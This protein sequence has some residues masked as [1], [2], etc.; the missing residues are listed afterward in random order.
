MLEINTIYEIQNIGKGVITTITPDNLLAIYYKAEEIYTE[1]I[2][3]TLVAGNRTKE[4]IIFYSNYYPE[5]ELELSYFRLYV[6]NTNTGDHTGLDNSGL[7]VGNNSSGEEV[8]INKEGV[9]FNGTRLRYNETST[10][11]GAVLKLPKTTNLQTKVILAEGDVKVNAG[12][13]VTVTGNG[14]IATPFVINS[15]S[16]A[17]LSFSDGVS[18]KL[19]GSGTPETPYKY[20]TLNLQKEITVDYTLTASDDQQTLFINNTTPITITI[21][22]TG[23]PDNFCVGFVH[24]TLNDVTYAGS[25]VSNPIGLKSKGKGY[26]QFIE[27]KLA[28]STYYLLG[29]TKV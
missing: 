29:N 19:V 14:T 20:E 18:T 16:T 15:V 21:P 26:Q 8:T 23:L 27:R 17:T 12:T 11:N 4:S 22:A 24:E 7:S 3:E 13:N 25:G 28:T 1:D 2:Q 10:G 9:N 6:Q 5:Q